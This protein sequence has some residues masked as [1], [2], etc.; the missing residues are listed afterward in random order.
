MFVFIHFHFPAFAAFALPIPQHLPCCFFLRLSSVPVSNSSAA[1]ISINYFFLQT[2]NQHFAT[3]SAKT[4]KSEEGKTGEA[5]RCQSDSFKEYRNVFQQENAF[6]EIFFSARASPDSFWSVSEHGCWKFPQVGL[7]SLSD[8]NFCILF[9]WNNLFSFLAS[10]SGKQDCYCIFT[11]S[12][13]PKR[14]Q[15]FWILEFPGRIERWFSQILAELKNFYQRFFC[16]RTKIGVIARCFL[17]FCNRI[18]ILGKTNR[19]NRKAGESIEPA[20]MLLSRER[21]METAVWERRKAFLGF[22]QKGSR[23]RGQMAIQGFL[24]GE[25]FQWSG[26]LRRRKEVG[27]GFPCWGKWRNLEG[28]FPWPR[29]SASPFSAE[30][31]ERMEKWKKS[32][33]RWNWIAFD[34]PFWE[35]LERSEFLLYSRVFLWHVTGWIV[36]RWRECVKVRMHHDGALHSGPYTERSTIHPYSNATFRVERPVGSGQQSERHPGHPLPV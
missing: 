33:W 11:K 29:M 20:R 28:N 16:I 8:W 9:Q 12:Q 6:A 36:A 31:S 32:V 10:L 30:S 35:R 17:L 3:N 4:G 25:L 2:R 7:L 19:P 34:F 21:R 23:R 27:N 1:L 15:V 18:Y 5:E 24:S 26:K 14:S 22:C 13:F